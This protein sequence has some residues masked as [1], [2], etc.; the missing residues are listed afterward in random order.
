MPKQLTRPI[1]PPL[2]T[3]RAR[4]TASPAA[5]PVEFEQ[6]Y[7]QY[8]LRVYRYCLRRVDVPEEAEDLT[9]VIFTRALTHFATYRG[10]LFEAWL[11]RIAHNVVVNHLRDRRPAVSLDALGDADSPLPWPDSEPDMLEQMVHHEEKGR[12]RHLMA[13]LPA[14]EQELLVLKLNAGL[15]ARAIGEVVGKSEGAVRVAIYRVIQRL[16]RAWQADEEV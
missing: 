16:R 15:S 7:A 2:T 12:L 3:E 13:T 4:P 6:I 8:F 9:S 1:G 11:F 10:G 14:D 5:P